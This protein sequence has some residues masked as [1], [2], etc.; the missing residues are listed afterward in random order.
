MRILVISDTHHKI[1]R[2]ID[3]LQGD[4][5]FDHIIHLGDLVSD[6]RDIAS[7]FDIPMTCVSGN[8]D[9]YEP[10][11]KSEEILQF[12]NISILATHG[13]RYHVKS[14]LHLLRK[15]VKKR[16][17]NIVLFGHSHKA[18]IEYFED[19]I[20]MNPGSISLPKDGLPS[21]GVIHIDKEGIAHVN[22][23]RIT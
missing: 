5:R 18:L 9:Y 16:S 8:C 4:H 22:I 15:E 10:G 20:I 12:G 21:F 13:H 17:L 14:S 3:L 19:A 11:T 6:A 1:G 23:A 7:I 2:V